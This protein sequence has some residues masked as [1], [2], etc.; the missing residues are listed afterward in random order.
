MVR[1]MTKYVNITTISGVI[2]SMV[3]SQNS[4]DV[5]DSENEDEDEADGFSDDGSFASVDDLDGKLSI[6]QRLGVY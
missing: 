3:L 1:T 5:A 6:L 2:F 4:A